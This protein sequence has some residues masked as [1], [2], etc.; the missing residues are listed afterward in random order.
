VSNVNRFT[1][2]QREEQRRLIRELY[3]KHYADRIVEPD[4]EFEGKQTRV[5]KLTKSQKQIL[6]EIKRRRDS[7]TGVPLQKNA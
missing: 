6:E 7:H 1:P 5:R 4:P 3:E 2:E